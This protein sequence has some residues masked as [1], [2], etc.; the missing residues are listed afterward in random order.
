V[1]SPTT[2]VNN[3]VQ[4]LNGQVVREIEVGQ[5]IADE[6]RAL[7][8]KPL[9]LFEHRVVKPLA[10]LRDDG[11]IFDFFFQSIGLDDA[12]AEQLF[13]HPFADQRREDGILRELPNKR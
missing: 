6:A 7:Q 4:Q 3:D 13:T 12:A 8:P 5:I 11:P 9:V 1:R 10:L 2:S